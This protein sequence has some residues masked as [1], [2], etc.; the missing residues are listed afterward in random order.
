MMTRPVRPWVLLNEKKNAKMNSRRRSSVVPPSP[1]GPYAATV[2][3]NHRRSS[4]VPASAQSPKSP[5]LAGGGGAKKSSPSSMPTQ[6]RVTARHLWW[7]L[8]FRLL[9]M[10][11]LASSIYA[12]R[13]VHPLSHYASWSALLSKSLNTSPHMFVFLVASVLTAAYHALFAARS[14]KFLYR[15]RQKH[16]VVTRA[17]GVGHPTPKHFIIRIRQQ[18]VEPWQV[19]LLWA[20]LGAS[21]FRWTYAWCSLEPQACW[22]IRRQVI[23][24]VVSTA[25][26]LL[27]PTFSKF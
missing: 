20:L 14:F 7:S 24:T 23:I 2:N 27:F 16:S 6:L 3:Q 12:V 9:N 10:A 13:Q 25:S 15:S 21:L 17:G 19:A 4:A 5:L 22:V 11:L 1:L 26:T 18:S 8:A